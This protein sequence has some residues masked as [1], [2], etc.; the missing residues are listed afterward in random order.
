MGNH[1]IQFATFCRF[2]RSGGTSSAGTEQLT[3]RGKSLVDV[4]ERKGTSSVSWAAEPV[5]KGES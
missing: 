5:L 1:Q 3:E 4:L 2:E